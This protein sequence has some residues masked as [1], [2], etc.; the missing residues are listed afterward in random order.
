MAEQENNVVEFKSSEEEFPYSPGSLLSGAIGSAPGIVKDEPVRRDQPYAVEGE[1]FD[2]DAKV[3]TTGE[4]AQQSIQQQNISAICIGQ[5]I[6]Q[7]I[8]KV[9][10]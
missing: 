3:L 7:K 2:G 4:A 6:D 5:S 8:I 10:C 9:K 1:L